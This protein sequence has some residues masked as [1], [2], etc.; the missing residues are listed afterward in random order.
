[1]P[2]QFC[3]FRFSTVNDVQGHSLLICFTAIFCCWTGRIFSS[4]PPR[5]HL[6]LWEFVEV[7]QCLPEQEK[8]YVVPAVTAV[9]LFCFSQVKYRLVW[10]APDSHAR[11]LS[12]VLWSLL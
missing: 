1:M 11:E 6:H 5:L 7:Q 4:A 12:R 3:A 9:A 8:A 2:L 10:P